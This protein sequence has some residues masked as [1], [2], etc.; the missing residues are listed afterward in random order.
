MLY[1]LVF[2]GKALESSSTLGEGAG[3]VRHLLTQPEPPCYGIRAFMWVYGNTLL[4]FIHNALYVSW[5]PSF[6][7]AVNV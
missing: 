4:S 6:Q 7:T 2:F 5:C 1:V 3:S